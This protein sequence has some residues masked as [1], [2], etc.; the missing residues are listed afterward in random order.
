MLFS[1]VATMARPLLPGASLLSLSTLSTMLGPEDGSDG[2]DV[3]NVVLLSLTVLGVVVAIGMCCIFCVCPCA[4]TGSSRGEKRRNKKLRNRS[5][6]RDAS[7]SR[8]YRKVHTAIP[9][10]EGSSADDRETAGRSSRAPSA[11]AACD[12][13]DPLR[14]DGH[15]GVSVNG[16]FAHCP[17]SGCGGAERHLPA[18]HSQEVSSI[19]ILGPSAVSASMVMNAPSAVRT[20]ADIS[21]PLHLRPQSQSQ[22]NVGYAE[23]DD[24]TMVALA[25]LPPRSEERARL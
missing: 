18:G 12:S 10:D 17:D 21:G 14:H 2:V 19:D 22:R 9:V 3:Q 13:G 11:D 23:G 7:R 20:L 1:S 16:S 5:K 4:L 24:L 15:M 6:S 25:R 8:N